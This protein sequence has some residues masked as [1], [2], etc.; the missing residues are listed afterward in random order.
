M[1]LLSQCLGEFPVLCMLAPLFDSLGSAW[2]LNS[3]RG[4]CW[5]LANC[6]GNYWTSH[7]LKVSQRLHFAP[8]PKQCC[9]SLGGS[10]S[11][12]PW[13]LLCF[14]S[15]MPTNLYMPLSSFPLLPVCLLQPL[16]KMSGLQEVT[17]H[18]DRLIHCMSE[19]QATK[20]FCWRRLFFWFLSLT[21]SSYSRHLT[22]QTD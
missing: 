13:V 7:K 3:C 19:I 17:E 16:R 5:G 2:E 1:N 9:G 14:H 12:Q 21:S 8:S 18:W 4:I 15:L 20:I 22:T 6:A 10:C 11:S